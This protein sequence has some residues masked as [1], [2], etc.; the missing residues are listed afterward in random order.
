MTDTENFTA[1]PGEP[2]AEAIIDLELENIDTDLEATVKAPFELSVDRTNWSTYVSFP[3]TTNTIY[4]RLGATA[5]G[6][7]ESFVTITGG[8]ATNDEILLTGTVATAPEH[9][10]T[11]FVADGYELTAT[12]PTDEV[13]T[14]Y[15]PGKLQPQ[16]TPF[17]I[18]TDPKLFLLRAIAIHPNS[19]LSH[20]LRVPIHLMVLL[21][22]IRVE[23]LKATSAYTPVIHSPLRLLRVSSSKK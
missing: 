23:N 7:Y 12:D 5:I 15:N 1:A 6:E 19:Q 9:G 18:P 4:V 14:L 11:H 10:V 17:R 16:A 21:Y 20:F 13:V 22:G 8:G 2:S 3:A